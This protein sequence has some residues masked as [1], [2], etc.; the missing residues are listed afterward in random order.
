MKPLCYAELLYFEDGK[1]H[2]VNDVM[3]DLKDQYGKFR[4]FNAKAIHECMM[5]AQTNGILDESG[6]DLDEDDNLR[7][8]WKIND[9]GRKL[10]DRFLK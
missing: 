7:I 8:Y 9:Y 1:D 4:M 5:T 3:R 2:C 10:M 6:A